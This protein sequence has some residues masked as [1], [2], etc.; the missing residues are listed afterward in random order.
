MEYSLTVAFV[1]SVF[2]SA[3]FVAMAIRRFV[4]LLF[5]RPQE[6]YVVRRRNTHMEDFTIELIEIN[7]RPMEKELNREEEF[8]KVA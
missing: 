8:K 2:V 5:K 6:F 1:I 7:Q 4:C 3:I